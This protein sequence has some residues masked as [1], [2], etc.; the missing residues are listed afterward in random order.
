[1]ISKF[2][3]LYVGFT[4]LD[5][6]GLGGT[7]PDERR[8]SNDQIVKAYRMSLDMARHMDALGFDTLWGAEHH[9]QR[10]GYEE[11]PHL[12][13]L[14]DMGVSVHYSRHWGPPRRLR[15]IALWVVGR[16]MFPRAAGQVGGGWL[17]MDGTARRYSALYA[18][19]F[20]PS[21]HSSKSS[22]GRS[23]RSYG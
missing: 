12:R 23:S 13:G 3:V 14:G 19:R 6:V 2:S 5:N 16:S 9:F 10:E 8:L 7:P 18:G 11:V 17:R 20:R 1:M 21:S 22:H 15:A 4:E